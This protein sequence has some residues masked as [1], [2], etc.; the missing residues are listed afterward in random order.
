M[1]RKDIHVTPR[2]Q[3]WAGIVE[4]NERASFIARTKSEAMD[5]ARDYAR[6]HRVERVEHGAD[7]RIRGSDSFGNDPCPPRDKEH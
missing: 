1:S 6:D 4:G 7:G 2:P 3:G 5:R